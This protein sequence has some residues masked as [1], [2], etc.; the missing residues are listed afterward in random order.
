ME[1]LSGFENLESNDE[2]VDYSFL[3]D[4]LTESDDTSDDES[5]Q[6]DSSDNETRETNPVSSPFHQHVD[7]EPPR[8]PITYTHR[9]RNT[10]RSALERYDDASRTAPQSEDNLRRTERHKNTPSRFISYEFFSP[11]HRVCLSGIHSYIEPRNFEEARKCP[12]WIT[13]MDNELGALRRAKTWE[14]QDL[15]KGK[16][17]I[18]CRWVF[19]VKTKSDG[20]LERYKARLVA[21][22]YSQEYVI[23]Y[24]ETFAPIA[25]MVTV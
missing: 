11:K 19:K 12:K 18:G 16:K 23:D 3:F 2:N 5:N 7:E 6:N 9:D 13:A 10:F 8:D 1:N 14:F 21:N 24:E 25:R 4:L 15:P 20:S 17:T 22:G